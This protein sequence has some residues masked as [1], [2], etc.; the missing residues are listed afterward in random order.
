MSLIVQN[1]YAEL[2][3]RCASAAFAA[4]FPLNGSFVRVTIKRRNYWYFQAGRRGESGTQ[5]RKYVGPD[6]A[7]IRRQIAEHGRAKDDYRERRRLIALLHRSGFQSPPD[8]VGGVLQALSAAGVFRLRACLVGTSAYQVYGPMLG[9]RLPIASLQTQ[10]V[11]IAQF[12]AVSLAIAKDER[13]PSL[14]QILK[15]ADPTFRAVPRFQD[16]S[17]TV[18]YVNQRGL[19]VEIL[20]ESRGPERQAPT[21]LPSIGTHAQ[22]LRFLDFLIR[23]ERRAAVLHDV[24]VLVNVPAPERYA[25]HKLIIT[26]RRPT[27]AAKIDK[28]FSQAAAL[29]RVLTDRR[30]SQLREAWREATGRGPK[31]RQLLASGLG[32]ISVK[33]RDRTLQIVGETRAFVPGVDLRFTD[34]PIRYDEDSISVIL[35][36][37]DGDELIRC[38][39]RR[40]ALLDEYGADG[41]TKKGYIDAF[42]RHRSEIERLVRHAYLSETIKEIGVVHI[43]ALDVPRLRGAL[44]AAAGRVRRR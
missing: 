23:D 30:A 28:D 44:G 15:T 19:R 13:I 16:P 29:L 42:Q 4:D 10:D 14:I 9:V 34:D 32:A 39:I 33:I 5:H 8:E 26:Q 11:D 22:P 24:G 25:L 20:A 43:D 17:T 7:E 1:L 35:L 37:E 40:D 3:D 6:N 18:A 38:L 2:V 41:K 36:G 12:S 21:E 31:W 27:G